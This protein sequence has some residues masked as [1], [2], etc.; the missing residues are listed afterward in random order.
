MGSGTMGFKEIRGQ[1]AREAELYELDQGYK[2]DEARAKANTRELCATTTKSG[3][4]ARMPVARRRLGVWCGMPYFVFQKAKGTSN[5]TLKGSF[6]DFGVARDA[7]NSYET[8]TMVARMVSAATESEARGK[9]GNAWNAI[10][11]DPDHA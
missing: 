2:R 1:L 8:D 3:T 11:H 5:W 10:T 4:G 9:S 6:K 7:R